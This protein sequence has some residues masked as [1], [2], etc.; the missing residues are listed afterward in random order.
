MPAG[1][2]DPVTKID[3]WVMFIGEHEFEIEPPSDED[4]PKG[5][6]RSHYVIADDLDPYPAIASWKP[7][8]GDG[9]EYIT[10]VVPDNYNE[11]E[12]DIEKSEIDAGEWIRWAREDE[13]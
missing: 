6:P 1:Y 3:K 7:Y 2:C 8:Y 10:V 12:F 9:T 4:S 11:W 5:T 13:I